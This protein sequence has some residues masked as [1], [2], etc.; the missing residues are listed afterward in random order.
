MS[1][2][3]RDARV[4]YTAFG[5]K[6][7][8]T[9]SNGEVLIAVR[10]HDTKRFPEAQTFVV[11]TATLNASEPY[12]LYSASKSDDLTARE[13]FSYNRLNVSNAFGAFNRRGY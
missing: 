12:A 7:G 2:Q 13:A 5:F 9:L 6:P 1:K 10:E 8:E 4:V 11:L 3:F